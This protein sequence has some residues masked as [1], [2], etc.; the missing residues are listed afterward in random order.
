MFKNSK[1]SYPRTETKQFYAVLGAV[2]FLAIVCL[3]ASLWLSPVGSDNA[4]ALN[5]KLLA[6]FL[7][8]SG[9]IIGLIANRIGRRS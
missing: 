8:A 3:L 9:A 2:L 7:F 4:K 5:D 1:S 6:V